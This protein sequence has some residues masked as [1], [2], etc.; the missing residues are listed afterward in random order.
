MQYNDLTPPNR[1]YSLLPLLRR[2]RSSLL[3]RYILYYTKESD[4]GHIKGTEPFR[5]T[6][7]KSS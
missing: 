4:Y 2:K 1:V 3:L 6:T 7:Q 5:A